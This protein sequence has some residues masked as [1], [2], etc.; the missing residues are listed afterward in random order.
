[1]TTQDELAPPQ[2]GYA[3]ALAWL[4]GG[5]SL[6]DVREDV[7]WQ[8]GHAPG[9]VHIPLGDLEQERAR[10]QGRIVVICRS[11]RRSNLAAEVLRR[12]GIDAANFAGGM[13][14]WQAAGGAVITPSG[15]AGA[16]I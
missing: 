2:L 8:A 10:M 7:E 16:V 14:D 5:A 13:Q 12:Q 9:A 1:M 4:E 15:A 11:G 6:L 3:E